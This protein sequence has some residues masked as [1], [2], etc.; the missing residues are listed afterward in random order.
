MKTPSLRMLAS[1]AAIFVLLA[2]GCSDDDGAGGDPDAAI[3]AAS[4]PDLATQPETVTVFDRVRVNSKGDVNVRKA[5]APLTI[6]AGRYAKA[7]LLVELETSCFPFES[8]QQNPP[9]AGQNWPANC[10]A[11]DRNFE[12]RL[13]PP[14]DAATD[15]P[16][17]ELMRAITPF[18]GPLSLEIDVTDVANALPGDHT[19]RVVIPTYSDGKGLISGS[20]GGWWVSVK[21]KTEPGAPPRKVLAVIPLVDHSY[22]HDSGKVQVEFEVPAGTTKTKLEYRVTG[23]GGQDTAGDPACI[24]GA[25]EFCQRLHRVYLDGNEISDTLAP[26]RTDCDTLCTL[27]KTSTGR[28]YC[29]ENPC[30]SIASV[31]A[32]RANWC[33]GSLTPPITFVK[34]EA[35]TPGKH[36]FAYEIEKVKEGGSW[37]VSAVV[38]AYE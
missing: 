22:K 38:F 15:P 10:D 37:R 29:A 26:W 33:P 27:K 4:G 21:L 20:D 7:T 6:K 35:L 11:F 36:S 9:P 18:G 13:N 30:G 1:L 8:W 16:S 14:K 31:R 25:E 19:L 5:E 32:P 2:G 34:A 24:G 3:D 28:D 23:H 12:L 17:V